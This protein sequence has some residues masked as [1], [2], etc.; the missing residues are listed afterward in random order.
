VWSS[1]L[2]SAQVGVIWPYVRYWLATATALRGWARAKQGEPEPWIARMRQS[3]AAPQAL[4]RGSEQG[5]PTA[6]AYLAEVYLDIGQAEEG[7]DVLAKTLL[8]DIS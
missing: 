1:S 5:R 7:L 8:E 4:G 6:L 2:P 3:L